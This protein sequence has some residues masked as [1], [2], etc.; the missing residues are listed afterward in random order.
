MTPRRL[1]TAVAL[2]VLLAVSGKAQ[3]SARGSGASTPTLRTGGPLVAVAADG[4]R[5]A[6]MVSGKARWR[7]LA[8]EPGSGRVT[9]I[10]TIVDP[11]CSKGCGPGGSLALAGTRVAWDE[12]G[13]GNELETVVNTATLTRRRTTSL[14]VGSWD[15]SAG[16]GGDEA[17]GPSGDRKLVAFTVQVHCADPDSGGEPVCPAGRQPD[18]VVSATVW[19]VARR[20][21]CPSYAD[22]R[23]LGHCVRVAH[24]NGELS[25][26]AVDAGRIAAR[27]DRGIRLLASTG[28]RLLD[29]PVANVRAAALSGNRLALRVP[30]AFEIHDASSGELLQSIPAEGSAMLDRLE[31]LEHGILVTAMNETVTVRRL[32]DGRTA[33]FELRGRAHA[34][35]EP[36]GLFLAG[37]HRITF[38]PM[39]SVLDRLG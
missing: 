24:A 17:F 16:G 6:L 8:W 25:V 26:L 13:G 7:I 29:F 5:V 33:T 27:T 10:A 37:G 20:G 30:G 28:L 1:L 18:E 14:G 21:R 4:H 9:P 36:T 22:Y 31:D 38:T 15:W 39:A 34:Q 19:K 11:G 32:S 3:S 12:F 35:L 2:A 23:P